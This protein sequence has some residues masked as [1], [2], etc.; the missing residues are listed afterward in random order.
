MNLAVTAQHLLP[1]RLLTQLAGWLARRPGPHAPFLIRRFIARY[2]VD[3]SKAAKIGFSVPS[4]SN[5]HP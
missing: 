5:L 3:M 1:K 2:K 4:A